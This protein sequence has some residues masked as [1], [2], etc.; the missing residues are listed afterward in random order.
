MYH[1]VA[2]GGAPESAGY[3]VSPRQFQEQLRHLR[4][5]GYQSVSQRELL[6]ATAGRK[7]LPGSRVMLTFD[8]GYLD[9]LTDAWPLLQRYGFGATVFLVTDRVGESNVWDAELGETIPLL[10]WD[11]IRELAAQGV[12]FGS[13]TCTHPFLGALSPEEVVEEGARSR[14]ILQEELGEP[15]WAV[16]YPYG[17][18]DP[19]IQQWM[20]GCG[21]EMGFTARTELWRPY[22]QPLAIPRINVSGHGDIH[23][24]RENLPAL[25]LP[26]EEGTL[27]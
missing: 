22:V 7:P 26:V 23:S 9:F 2:A 6:M 19:A 14:W 11:Q 13:H 4:Q 1:R 5:A 24:F 25:D 21:Y 10:E 20:G 17:N 3:R 18:T 27:E 8:D 15:V 12:E 16:A